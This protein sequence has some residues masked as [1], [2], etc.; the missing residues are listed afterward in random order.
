MRLC[1]LIAG[2]LL[3]FLPLVP[4]AS[5][6]DSE[7]RKATE[8]LLSGRLANSSVLASDALKAEP[9]SRLAHWLQAQS[10]IALAGKPVQLNGADRDLL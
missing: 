1:L 3:S 9:K 8:A 7:L 10:M 2:A 5:A 4:P 6:A